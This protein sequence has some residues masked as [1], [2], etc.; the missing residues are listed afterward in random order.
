MNERERARAHVAARVFFFSRNVRAF[1]GY[2]LILATF[3]S[4]RLVMVLLPFRLDRLMRPD[5]GERK[6]EV[7]PGGCVLAGTWQQALA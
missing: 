4:S 7:K 6:V 2:V 5:D 3:R 1:S